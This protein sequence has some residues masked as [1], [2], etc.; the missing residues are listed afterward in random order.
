MLNREELFLDAH[1]KALHAEHDSVSNIANKHRGA[2]PQP[3][4]GSEA[5]VG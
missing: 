5:G 3:E 1:S 4:C 2:S